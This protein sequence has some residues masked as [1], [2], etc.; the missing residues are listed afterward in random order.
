M[1]TS[2]TEKGVGSATHADNLREKYGDDLEGKNKKGMTLS[3]TMKSID[4]SKLD[5]QEGQA[6]GVL[7]N[8]AINPNIYSDNAMYG[9]MSNQQKTQAKLDAQGGIGGAVGI[10]A[11]EASQKASQQKGAVEGLQSEAEKIGQKVGKSAAEVMEETAGKLAAGKLEKDV[12]TIKGA[13][14]RGGYEAAS[15]K[16]GVEG[17][18]GMGA[19]YDNMSAMIKSED[20]DKVAQTLKDR[21]SMTDTKR[22]LIEDIGTFGLDK[23]NKAMGTDFHSEGA[24]AAALLGGAAVSAEAFQLLR[25]QKGPIRTT[26]GAAG[27]VYDKLTGKSTKGILDEGPQKSNS[28]QT[29]NTVNQNDGTHGNSFQDDMKHYTEEY[30]KNKEAWKSEDLNRRQLEQKRADILAK[31]P[32]ADVDGLDRQIKSSKEKLF[33]Y[34]RG[35]QS[36]NAGYSNTRANAVKELERSKTLK[37]LA[38]HGKFGLAAAT[39]AGAGYELY[40]YLT[41]GGAAEGVSKVAEWMTSSHGPKGGSGQTP[42]SSG[43]KSSGTNN[44]NI[45]WGKAVETGLDAANYLAPV[46]S[47]LMGSDLGSA[48]FNSFSKMKSMSPTQGASP[49]WVKDIKTYSPAPQYAQNAFSTPR[50]FNT[51]QAMGGKSAYGDMTDVRNAGASI[52]K[53]DYSEAMATKM[54]D[55]NVGIDYQIEAQEEQAEVSREFM[56]KLINNDYNSNK[57]DL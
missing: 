32:T 24:A 2:A 42:G 7:A 34:E 55:V 51:M 44:S 12:G 1:V 29:Q 37:S 48:E 15:F 40:D 18:A 10:D 6:A 45:S 41:D 3:E 47:A 50:G 11:M 49:S 33:E 46:A 56:E 36:A 28:Q 25:G 52:H 23:F 14:K 38:K 31:D 57:G 54:Q 13:E 17:G 30:G 43:Y 39:V 53:T 4:S 9:E 5:S 22:H 35:M 8:K 27:K 26:V 16:A 19:A 21:T 20:P